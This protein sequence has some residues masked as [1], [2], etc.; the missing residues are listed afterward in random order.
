MSC[1]FP[2]TCP[3]PSCA[4]LINNV[5]CTC[6]CRIEN[7][8]NYDTGSDLNAAMSIDDDSS[9]EDYG[10]CHLF[11]VKALTTIF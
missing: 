9:E 3:I 7:S 2:N 8:S 6:I 5:R 4:F 11:I 10:F 1:S